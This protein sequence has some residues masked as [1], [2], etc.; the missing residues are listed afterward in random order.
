MNR[1][2]VRHILLDI[3]GTTCPIEFV[4]EILFPFATERMES[5]LMEQSHNVMVTQLRLQV[6]DA[7]EKDPDPAAQ[8]LRLQLM[9]DAS[10]THQAYTSQPSTAIAGKPADDST[11]KPT[12][13]YL[14]W[15][16]QT[17]RKLPALKELQG[18]IWEEGY[19]SGTLKG[20][21]FEDVAPALYRWHTAGLKLSVYSSGS[22]KAQRL[23]YQ[24]SSAGDLRHLFIQWFDTRLGSK[25]DPSSYAAI[26]KHLESPCAQILF[27]SDSPAELQAAETAG[28]QLLLS[29]RGQ[30]ITGDGNHPHYSCIRTF[31]DFD[32]EP[33]EPA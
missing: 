1:E 20:P 18:M 23:L 8:E 4:S 28:Y 16:I 33:C 13:A 17:D 26:A 9:H 15:L 5:F 22:V 3:E 27:I 29:T 21:L 31:D 24:H 6:E 14:R 32:P 7:W 11:L 25:H 2:P 12:A 30:T 19:R 10:K